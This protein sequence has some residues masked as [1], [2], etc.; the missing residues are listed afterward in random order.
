MTWC[1]IGARDCGCIVAAIVDDPDTRKA[2]ARAVSDWILEGLA[3]TRADSEFVRANFNGDECPHRV[4]Q[5]RLE[6][7]SQESG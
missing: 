5:L 4:A 2:V 6:Q 7:A 1:Y 3:V